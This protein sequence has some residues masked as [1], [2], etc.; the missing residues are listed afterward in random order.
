MLQRW[1]KCDLDL[2]GS[3]WCSEILTIAQLTMC[4]MPQSAILAAAVAVKEK[5]MG[6]FKREY[7][8]DG[9]SRKI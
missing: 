3:N 1:T 2:Q 9:H 4:K 8:P 7:I 5:F 6:L